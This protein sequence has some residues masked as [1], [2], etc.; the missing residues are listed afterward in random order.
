MNKHWNS[1]FPVS[2]VSYQI[3]QLNEDDFPVE[4]HYVFIA[5]SAFDRRI[6]QQENHQD[7][8]E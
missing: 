6:G 8:A 1:L 4:A 7:T 3:L 2:W 5:T